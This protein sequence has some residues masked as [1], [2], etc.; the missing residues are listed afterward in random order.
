MK[1]QKVLRKVEEF[2]NEGMLISE[3][4]YTVFKGGRKD[5][6]LEMKSRDKFVKVYKKR[7]NPNYSCNPFH[8]YFTHLFP[9]LRQDSNVLAIYDEGQKR[10]V[11]MDK[12]SMAIVLKISV[13]HCGRFITESVKLKTMM[14]SE[15]GFVIN[16][17]Y[18]YNGR[19]INLTLYDLFKTSEVFIRSLTISDMELIFKT[20]GERV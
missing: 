13:G 1:A 6:E 14:R 12:K 3:D 4:S 2:D 15:L 9:Y 20:Y 18:A 19:F 5:N 8:L 16:P 17:A 11:N 7:F 10:Y